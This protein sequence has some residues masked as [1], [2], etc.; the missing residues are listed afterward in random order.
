MSLVALTSLAQELQSRVENRQLELERIVQSVSN[1]NERQI[2][3]TLLYY[4][5]I[6]M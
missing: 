5:V 3:A 2:D 6:M 1:I 4:D